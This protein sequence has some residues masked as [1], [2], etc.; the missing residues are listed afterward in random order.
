MIAGVL[1]YWIIGFDQ[2]GCGQSTPFGELQNNSSAELVKDVHQI[3]QYLGIKSWVL[4]GGSW[5]STLALLA[6]IDDPHTVR[7][8]ILRGIFLGR[9]EDFDWYLDPA[10]GAAQLFTDYYHDFVQGISSQASGKDIVQAYYQL[11]TSGNE[12]SKMAAIK[13][14]CLWEARIS[15][16]HCELNE[17]HLV[18]N[19]HRAISLALL[20]CHYIINNCFIPENFI[21][22]N[23]DK[24]GHIPG[25][26]VHGRYD[27][28][29]K[30][31]GAFALNQ[32]WDNSQLT[33]VPE[34]GH[35]TY[36][37]KIAAALCLA[38]KA[39]A[40]FLQEQS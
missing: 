11:F 15:R 1:K 19:I 16:L 34:S 6:A 25:N 2:R 39:M 38:T 10:G 37:P 23:I 32:Y 29:C 9:E 28:V 31:Q 17:E 13:A 26:I 5:G 18:S 24:I 33:I 40:K 30:I 35:S 14:W 3:R 4:F 22:N 20:E 12:L 7:G 36:E 8:L 27:C 21:L